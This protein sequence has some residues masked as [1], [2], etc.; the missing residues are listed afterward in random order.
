[1]GGRG[2][3]PA[4]ITKALGSLPCTLTGSLQEKRSRRW[5]LA[6]V[7]RLPNTWHE[8]AVACRFLF[9]PSKLVPSFDPSP[10]RVLLHDLPIESCNFDLG[11]ASCVCVCV[12]ACVCVSCHPQRTLSTELVQ[13]CTS[14]LYNRANNHNA[15]FSPTA[16]GNGHMQGHDGSALEQ[17]CEPSRHTAESFNCC[18]YVPVP[19]H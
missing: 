12:C 6:E 15:M 19:S 11:C 4:R 5:L 18:Q 9:K 2:L 16:N 1:M 17:S 10:Y 13:Q 3:A 8:R 14:I 7:G